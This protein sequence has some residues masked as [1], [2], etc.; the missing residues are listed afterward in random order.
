V[1]LAPGTAKQVAV[2]AIF[3]DGSASDVARFKPCA[4]D[5]SCA[6]LME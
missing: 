4:G 1:T 6:V 3:K 2:Q 5:A